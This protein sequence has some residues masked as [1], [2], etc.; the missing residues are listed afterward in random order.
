MDH[1]PLGEQAGE[2]LAH[3]HQAGVRQGAADEAGVEQVQDRV[4][5]PADILVDRQPFVGGG[6]G[7]RFGRGRIGEAG[8]IPAGIDEGV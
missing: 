7:D 5:D 8:E 4:L 1:H 2:G 6:A 3:R